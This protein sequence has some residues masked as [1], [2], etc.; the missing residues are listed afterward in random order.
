MKTLLVLRHAKA[1]QPEVGQ[2]DFERD[3]AKRGK[4]D[5]ERLGQVLVERKQIPQAVVASSARRTR[6]TAKRVVE[7]SGCTVEPTLTDDLY[8]AGLHDIVQVVQALPPDA[9]I[10]LIVGHNP[11]FGDFVYTFGQ[12]INDFPTAALAELRL[13][14]DAWSDLTGT[15]RG[16]LVSLWTPE[17]DAKN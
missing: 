8:E 9:D 2:L 1:E 7:S 16:E 10:A 17:T 11:G 5:A 13:P 4:Q 15:T 14:I 3:L 6:K 12:P